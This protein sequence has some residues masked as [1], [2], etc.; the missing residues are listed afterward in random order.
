MEN[1]NMR[2]KRERNC[3]YLDENYPSFP[4]FRLIHIYTSWIGIQF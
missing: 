4:S 3:E 1:V 2:M